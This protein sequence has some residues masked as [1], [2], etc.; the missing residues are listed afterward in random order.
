M[1]RIGA[2]AQA[3]LRTLVRSTSTAAEL[4]E[5]DARLRTPMALSR[6]VSF[7]AVT[8]GSGT[9]ATAASVAS[10]LAARRTGMVLAVDAGGGPSGLGWQLEVESGAG[11]PMSDPAATARRQTARSAADA[12][13]GLSDT[14]T[15]LHLL[16]LAE[17]GTAAA[18]VTE[19]RRSV[20]PIAR[21]FDLVVTEWGVRH[22]QGDLT[23]VAA[24]SHLVAVVARAERHAATAAA[25]VVPLLQDVSPAPRVVLVLVDVARTSERAFG[26]RER[27][28]VPVHQIGFDRQRAAGSPQDSSSLTARTRRE[29]I[30]LATTVL[31]EV[32]ATS[33][34]TPRL[35]V[36][37]PAERPAVDRD[38]TRMSAS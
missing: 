1:S 32:S 26:W 33:A 7:L 14:P 27:L 6:R 28:G 30:G 36:I 38:R 16:D 23:E 10:L 35:P 25:S 18:S 19:W 29:L 12:R 20:S 5:A 9:S 21:F 15:G 17:P 13:S 34:A 3:T 8:G 31:N 2:Q 37:A 24:T 11:K 4:T 22:W